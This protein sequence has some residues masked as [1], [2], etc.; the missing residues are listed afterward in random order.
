MSKS[1]RTK[2]GCAAIFSLPF[3]SWT[4]NL[5]GQIGPAKDDVDLQH[6]ALLE[7]CLVSIDE[8]G[9]APEIIALIE[10]ADELSADGLLD[11]TMIAHIEI[12]MAQVDQLDAFG[13][14]KE[15]LIEKLLS[16][17]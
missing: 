8:R 11:E 5:P 16:F 7:Q 1:K 12:A 17:I 13:K 6:Q 10:K 14:D 15:V 2:K 3:L 4:G 9:V